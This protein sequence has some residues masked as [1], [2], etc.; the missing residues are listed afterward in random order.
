MTGPVNRIDPDGCAC[1]DC[2]TGYSV[3]LD[4]A[5]AEDLWRLVQ[6]TAS[7]ATGHPLRSR[8]VHSVG[9]REVTEP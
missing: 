6:G 2:L 3:P 7:N 8:V 4:L 1:S 5:T 9:G